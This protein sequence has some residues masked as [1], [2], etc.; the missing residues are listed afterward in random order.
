MPLPKRRSSGNSSDSPTQGP[1]S[2]W[3]EPRFAGI[4]WWDWSAAP[5]VG[6]SQDTGFTPF[7]KPAEQVLR[8][9]Y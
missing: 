1:E 4:Y 2:V 5:G 9:W 8:S 7:E 3:D 6:G